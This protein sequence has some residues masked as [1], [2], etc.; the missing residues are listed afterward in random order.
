MSVLTK[1]LLCG[2]VSFGLMG[3]GGC[4]GKEPSSSTGAG[5]GGS[6]TVESTEAACAYVEARPSYLPWLD[7]GEPVPE[8]QL[9]TDNGTSYV[10]WASGDGGTSQKSVIFRRSS[11]PRGG[12]GEPVS[13]K[14]EGVRGYYY[15]SPGSDAGVLWKT[16][17]DACDLIT[18]AVSL[19]G[20]GR[21][22]VRAEVLKIVKSLE[23]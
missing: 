15:A 3:V 19:P 13:V 16:D 20:S 12:R 2:V 7:E 23:S 17:S 21:A 5:G 10:T 8:P 18:L 11:E 1:P 4:T 9:Q 6:P 14:L 22:E